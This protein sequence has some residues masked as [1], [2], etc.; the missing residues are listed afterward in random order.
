MAIASCKALSIRHHV[1]SHLPVDKGAILLVV[2]LNRSGNSPLCTMVPHPNQRV[3]IA[4]NLLALATT[5]RS[6]LY[7]LSKIT[8]S[9][10]TSALQQ[11]LVFT[12]ALLF[13]NGRSLQTKKFAQL[14]CKT[15]FSINGITRVLDLVVVADHH[16]PA[17]HHPLVQKSVVHQRMSP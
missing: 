9:L 10:A 8:F 5:A 6:I 7:H 2:R 3:H 1:P 11:I 16:H 15:L 13:S 4:T 14:P 12:R 17:V